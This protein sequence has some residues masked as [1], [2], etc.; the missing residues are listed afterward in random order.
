M[1]QIKQQIKRLKQNEKSRLLN[2]GLKSSMKTAIKNVELAVNENDVEKAKE[3]YALASK[4]LDKAVSKGIKHKNYAARQKS[5]L[6]K[7]INTI[8]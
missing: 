6:A 7:L 2:L 4:K 8:A 5:R 3:A 1:P